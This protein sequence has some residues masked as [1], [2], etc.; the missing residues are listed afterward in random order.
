MPRLSAIY[1]G[2]AE[3]PC[4]LMYYKK[5]PE[6]LLEDPHKHFDVSKKENLPLT[7]CHHCPKELHGKNAVTHMK[8]HIA[9]H[10]GTG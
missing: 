2:D 3:V 4:Q 10:T 1:Q 7:K 5:T 8:D 6:D 9:S